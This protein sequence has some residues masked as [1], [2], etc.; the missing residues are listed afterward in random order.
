M[1]LVFLVLALF[2]SVTAYVELIDACRASYCKLSWIALVFRRDLPRTKRVVGKWRLTKLLVSATII[3]VFVSFLLPAAVLQFFA[4]SGVPQKV[5]DEAPWF[6][7]LFDLEEA[8]FAAG[9]FALGF[10]V[11][12]V[13]GLKG[14]LVLKY[15]IRRD[16]AGSVVRDAVR[17]REVRSRNSAEEQALLE[18]PG[19]IG[20]VPF[21]KVFKVFVEFLYNRFLVQPLEGSHRQHVINAALLDTAAKFPDYMIANTFEARTRSRRLQKV[22]QELLNPEPLRDRRDITNEMLDCM[23]RLDAYSIPALW[24]AI[25]IY[26]ERRSDRREDLTAEIT[27]LIGGKEAHVVVVNKS[28]TGLG[29][30]SKHDIPIQRVATFPDGRTA[31]VRRCKQVDEGYVVGLRLNEI[32][33]G[34]SEPIH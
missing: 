16:I 11:A 14:H 5:V 30:I 25:R 18:S 21:L 8:P 20:S 17:K 9:V 7:S 10:A 33:G 34:A 2:A 6:P 15:T 19:W 28:D 32:S 12:V 22:R 13:I 26:G 23:L 24:S 1:A 31:V 27:I 4:S 3:N 29:V